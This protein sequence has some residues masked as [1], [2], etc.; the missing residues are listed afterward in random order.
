MLSGRF[1]V[2]E[3]Y[4]LGHFGRYNRY[5]LAIPMILD[6]PFGL[7]L[8]QIENYFPEPIHNVWIACFLYF[9]WIGGLAWTLLL[10]L[11]GMQAWNTWK[12]SRNGLC[13]MIFFGWLSIIS[14]SMLHEG[15]RWRFMWLL[16]GI[17]WG[18]NPRNFAAIPGSAHESRRVVAATKRSGDATPVLS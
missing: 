12:R 6:H 11:S 1:T 2:A 17:L 13:L 3:E 8:L 16:T 15:E 14:C 4:D 18:L 9:G 10:I 7:G 5:L